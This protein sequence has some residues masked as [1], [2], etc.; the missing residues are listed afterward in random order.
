M[1]AFHCRLPCLLLYI[2]RATSYSFG[3]TSVSAAAGPS[4]CS[5]F[6]NNLLLSERGSNTNARCCEKRLGCGGDRAQICFVCATDQG[7]G[8]LHFFLLVFSFVLEDIGFG[9]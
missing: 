9:P 3:V 1:Q 6:V 5:T 8:V 7:L 2:P 4:L